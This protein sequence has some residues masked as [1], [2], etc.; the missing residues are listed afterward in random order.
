LIEVKST[1][2]VKDHYLA[3]VAIQHKVVMGSGAIWLHRVW[4]MWIVIIYIKAVPST[5][6]VFSRS[7]I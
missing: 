7:E 5:H 1:T 3:D 6:T 4:R 2:Q